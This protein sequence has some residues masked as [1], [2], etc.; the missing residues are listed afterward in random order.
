MQYSEEDD[1]NDYSDFTIAV[2][3]KLAEMSGK[4]LATMRNFGEQPV[5]GN[6]KSDFL[7]AASRVT[8]AL[9]EFSPLNPS[10]LAEIW[11]QIGSPRD[12]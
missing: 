9:E 11:A 4:D 2:A 6:N 7:K 12:A 8:D 5:I 3:T 1:R 10:E